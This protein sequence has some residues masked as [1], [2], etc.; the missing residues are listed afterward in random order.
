MLMLCHTAGSGSFLGHL[1]SS[2][3][4]DDFHSMYH[5]VCSEESSITKGVIICSIL[6]RFLSFRSF[7]MY[8]KS[9][10]LEE[11]FSTI[12]VYQFDHLMSSKGLTTS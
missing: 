7:L 4:V 6:V 11:G 12:S 1:I 2:P 3:I 5:F 8:T 9:G 10:I